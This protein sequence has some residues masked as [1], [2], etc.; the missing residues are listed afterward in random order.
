MATDLTALNGITKI[1][2][3]KMHKAVPRLGWLTKMVPFGKGER[4]GTRW[5]ELVVLA[6]EQGHTAGGTSGGFYALNAS[7]AMATQPAYVI[8][9]QYTLRLTMPYDAMTRARSSGPRAFTKAVALVLGNGMDSVANREEISLH[10]GQ[11]NGYSSTSA[12][13]GGLGVVAVDAHEETS[14]TILTVQLSEAEWAPGIWAQS[15]GAIVEVYDEGDALETTGGSSDLEI[16][17]VDMINRKIGLQ[18]TSA[19]ITQI[20]TKNDSEALTIYWKGY[21]DNDMIGIQKIFS[22]TSGS[23]F[24]INASTYGQWQGNL[25]DAGG[26]ELTFEKLNGFCAQL[27]ARGLDSNIYAEVSPFTWADLNSEV[28]ALRDQ[29]SSYNKRMSEIGVKAIRYYVASGMVTVAANS[30]A[31][32]GLAFLFTAG[33]LKRIGSANREW[34]LPGQQGGDVWTHVSGFNGA[35]TH[36]FSDHAIFCHDPKSCG[37]VTN[38]VNQHGTS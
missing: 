1:V 35:E 10:Y 16:V 8:P 19:L 4:V 18:G 17:S 12:K 13:L 24:N 21:H 29:D 34:N 15:H 28:G 27:S 2:Y 26:A 38:I 30:V 23:L 3:G 11:A 25:F 6:N 5:E 9:S 36:I 7:K 31:K 14:S 32:G 37:L 20:E 33:V 22:N